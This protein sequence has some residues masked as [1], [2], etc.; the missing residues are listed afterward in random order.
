M[1]AMI[2]GSVYELIGSIIPSIAKKDDSIEI[3]IT[4][5]LRFKV[6]EV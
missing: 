2:G 1:V 5:V 4:K 3:N 6:A